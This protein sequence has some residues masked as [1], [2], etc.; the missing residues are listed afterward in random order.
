MS[1]FLSTKKPLVGK[2][3]RLLWGLPGNLIEFAS[4]AA[5][6]P[7][8]LRGLAAATAAGSTTA[9]SAAAG[10]AAIARAS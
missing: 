2:D 7:S 1:S 10:S 4:R 5:G 6:T 9:G 8:G 3:E